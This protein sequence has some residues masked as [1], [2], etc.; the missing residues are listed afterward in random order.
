MPVL[1]II[2]AINSDYLAKHCTGLGNALF[3]IA[4]SYAI[5]KKAGTEVYYNNVI[6]YGNLLESRYGFNHKNTILRNFREITNGR[7]VIQKEPVWRGFNQ[8]LIDLASANK[9]T[10]Y[11]IDGHL[12]CKRYF[13]EYRA[14]IIELLK[15][16]SATEEIVASHKHLY[17][18]DNKVA[19]HLRINNTPFTTDAQYYI[20]AIERMKRE[21]TDA[22]F[23]VFCDDSTEHLHF[24]KG[25]PHTVVKSDPDYIDIYILSKFKNYILSK[26][27]FC[28]WGWY[29][30]TG[31]KNTIYPSVRNVDWYD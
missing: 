6:I 2:T 4:A 7:L 14:D 3:Q 12:E 26:S 9:D 8:C 30:N 11:V 25:I 15:P 13:D 10:N 21:I 20:D 18:G 31:E 24:L 23:I 29:L 28:F 1:P 22:H 19:I 17:E 5:A 16:D 27:T